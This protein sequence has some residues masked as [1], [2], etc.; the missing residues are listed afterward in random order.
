MFNNNLIK[1]L[2]ATMGATFEPSNKRSTSSTSPTN[3][4]SP[5]EDSDSDSSNGSSGINVSSLDAIYLTTLSQEKKEGTEDDQQFIIDSEKFKEKSTAEKL[6]EIFKLQNREEFIG[7]FRCTLIRSI[8]LQGFIYLTEDH[9]CF[10]AYFPREQDIILKDGNLAKKTFGNRYERYHFTLQNDV[11]TYY[12]DPMDMYCPEEIIDLKYAVKVEKTSKKN[13]FKIVTPKRTYKFQ[14]DSQTSMEEWMAQLER[15]IVRA[16]N[17]GDNVK[18]VIPF[19]SIESIE[20]NLSKNFSNTIQIV[21]TLEQ[22]DREDYFFVVFS[23][24]Q[25]LYE[26]LLKC[27]KKHKSLQP[28]PSNLTGTRSISP[29]PSGTIAIKSITTL[30]KHRRGKS[31]E[32]LPSPTSPR[33][34]SRSPRSTTLE[35]LPNSETSDSQWNLTKYV[36]RRAQIFLKNPKKYISSFEEDLSEETRQHFRVHFALPEQEKLHAVFYGYFLRMLPV[37]GKF[38]VSD[39]YICFR[40]RVIGQNTNMILPVADIHFFKKTKATMLGYYGLEILTK[41]QQEMFFEFGFE[42]I[43]DRF[44]EI[45]EHKMDFLDKE[46][47]KAPSGSS[48]QSIINQAIIKDQLLWQQ[49]SS[50]TGSPKVSNFGDIGVINKVDKPLHITCLTIGSRGDVQPY[51]ALAKGLMKEGHKVRIATHG[52]YKD[53]I[54]GHGI[55]FGYVGG[56]PAELMVNRKNINTFTILSCDLK[57]FSIFNCSVF[58]LRTACLLLV[59]SRKFR[60]WLDDLLETSF[61]ACQGTDVI[62]ES[63]SA[64]AGIHIA[65][66]LGVAYFRA[67]TMPWTRTRAYPHAF[68]VPDH[69]L[70]G[71]YNYS[72]YILIENAFW[73]AIS[74]QVN[75][76]RKKTLKLRGTNLEKMDPSTVPFLYNFS[77]HIVPKAFDWADWIHVT[78]YWFLDNPDHGWNPPE[79]L[80]EFLDK[81]RKNK[82]PIVYIGFGSI[83]VDDPQAVT[84][85]I[86]EAVQKSGV[87]A[88]LSKGWSDRLQKKAN[89]NEE[90]NYPPSIYPL[91][92]VPHDW[93]FPKIDAVVHHGGA[94]TTAAGLRAGIPTIIK[95]FFGDQFFW[96]DRIDNM[97]IG[98]CLKKLNTDKLSDYLVKVTTDQ[99]IINKAALVGENIRKEDGVHNAI[100]SFYKDLESAKQRIFSQRNRTEHSTLATNT[101]EIEENDLNNTANVLYSLNPLNQDKRLSKSLKK[102]WT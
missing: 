74:P 49:W 51:I 98:F 36:S 12:V 14:A 86:V 67:F 62:I 96:G 92:S 25:S 95:P 40:S 91:K 27:W 97:G 69:D 37:Y 87:A 42:H 29:E 60:E 11:L 85:S 68:A 41:A 82:R 43:R 50:S 8:M 66:Y 35:S 18:I 46:K 58:V 101:F 78:G 34:P 52:E 26:E 84:K 22:D 70:K 7:E 24:S 100:Q 93:L 102:L 56:N 47:K 75:R 32:D 38:Y 61:K 5:I 15:S 6:Q 3:P 33:S 23:E 16:N 83:V 64:M 94:G 30:I 99:K 39:N 76:W 57:E 65:E 53:W 45:I 81:N 20:N 79:D 13:G 19:E 55:E 77:E 80:I 72:S 48:D 10:H 21:V 17:D 2:A 89:Q 90:E 9:I 59:F 88:I 31:R 44:V 71:P 63:P 73:L 4:I 28:Q 54:E 1:A